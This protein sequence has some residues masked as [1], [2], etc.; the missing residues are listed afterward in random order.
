MLRTAIIALGLF[1]HAS[2]TAGAMIMRH[3]VD[4]KEYLLLGEAH[5]PALVLLA[6]PSRDGAP[7]LFNGMGT[8]IAPDWVLTAAHAVDALQEQT[9]G[10]R[11]V[12]VKGRG[13]RVA[14]VIVHP[15]YEPQQVTNDVA[16][17]RL[18][19]PVRN[20]QPACLYERQDEIGKVVVLVGAGVQGTGLTGPSQDPDGALRGATSTVTG[21]RDT[22]IEWEFRSPENDATPLEGISGPGDSGGPA[23]IEANGQTCIAGVSSYQRTGNFEEGRYGVVEVYTRVSHYLPWIRLVTARA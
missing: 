14:E 23:Y 2:A 5:R 12:Y 16:L 13:Y 4:P 15:D 1:C 10:P 21:V 6:A 22:Q 3:D 19:Q 18:E 7:L 11:F 8:L 9:T 17:V 20:P